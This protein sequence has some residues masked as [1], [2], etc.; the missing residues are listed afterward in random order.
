MA[1]QFGDKKYDATPFRR[2]KARQEGQ[3]AK[4][5]DLSSVAL[6]FAG[7]SALL[8]LGQTAANQVQNFTTLHLTEGAWTIV[9]AEL[10]INQAV[11]LMYLIAVVLLP[12]LSILFMVALLI[13]VMQTGFLFLP[14]KLTFDFK[15]VNPI[16]GL[17]RL[18]SIQSV[19]RLLLGLFKVGVVVGV[20]GVSLYL[21]A[22]QIMS[23]SSMTVP[24]IAAYLAQITLW[25]SLKIAAAL[26]LLALLDYL[27]QKWKF[28]QD[29]RMTEQEMREEIKQTQG[30][31][32]LASRR[33]AVQRQLVMNRISNSVP[34]ADV[35]V[36]NPTELAVA[37]KYDPE[38]MT[39]PVVV[40]KGA[41]TLAQRIRRLALESH[42]P[43]VERKEL[44]RSLY[45]EVELNQEVPSSSY[46][47]VA[48]VLKYVYELQ[49]RPAPVAPKK[50]A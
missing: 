43:I 22:D 29:L 8:F 50:A 3:V 46:A 20:A 14:Q 41:G 15:K 40:A 49:G 11:K 9:N 45:K 4:S 17:K 23:V 18:F 6:L 7:V 26:L 31:P 30:D 27:F 39:A 19:V 33:R 21:E 28:E 1:E 13:N 2:Q 44:A 10:V 12:L 32:Q 48:E 5:Q 37:L 24:Q 38:S 35:V 16:Q 47:A 36:T 25:T 42:I 34:D